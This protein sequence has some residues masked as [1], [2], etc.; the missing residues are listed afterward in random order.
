MRKKI[1]STT[2]TRYSPSLEVGLSNEEVNKRKEDGLVNKTI[3][4]VG[5]SYWEI[6]RT[7]VLSFFNILLFTIAGF[8]IYAN[9]AD[10]DPNTKWYKGIFFVGVLISNII[11][12]LYQDLKAK[13]LMKKMKLI[14][15]KEV[16]V[17]R[18]KELI[19]INP[20]EIVLDDIISFSAGEQIVS[21]SI[22][23]EGTVTVNESLLTGE[24]DNIVKTVG[25]LIYS[26]TYVVS[27]KCLAQ[28]EKVG[29]EN[30][31]ETLAVKAK[32]FK[33]NPSHILKSLKRL[34]RVLGGIIIAY[35]LIIFVTYACLG[36]FS[37][38]ENFISIITPI[39][40]QL[41]A[42]IPAGL[43]LLTSVAL[44]S[45]VVSLFAKK[46]NVQD[47]YS[48]EMLARTDVLCT[49]KTGTITDG[50]M[51]VKEVIS[52]GEMDKKEISH[53]MSK[54]CEENPDS[55][56]TSLSLKE[57]FKG[58]NSNLK[59]EKFLAF[60]SENKYSAATFKTGVSYVFGAY[61]FMNLSNKKETIKAAEE[62]LKKGYRVLTVAKGMGSIKKNK[63]EGE[64]KAIGL[65]IIQ[66]HI[67]ED[68][69]ATFEWFRN[70]HVEIKV[71]SGDNAIT[72]SEIAKE[73]GVENAEKY[74]SLEGMSLEEVEKVAL[75]Y[76]V[77]GRVTPE[78]KEALVKALKKAKKTVA[79]TGDGV[80]DILALKRA[81]CSIAMDSGSQAA[82]N[83][84]HIVLMDNN[85]STMPSIVA[86]GRRVINNLQR[87]GSLF[88]TKTVFAIVISIGFWI[89]SLFNRHIA[90]PFTTNNLLVWE[91]LGIGLS[92]FF[93]ALEPNSAPIRKGFLSHILHK[94]I[95]AAFAIIFATAMCFF[96]F[97]LQNSGI[98]Y[99]GVGDLGFDILHNKVGRF[100]ATGMAVLTYSFL[101]FVMLYITCS[102]L[103]KYRAAVVIGAT[104]VAVIA[105]IIAIFTSPEKNI[106]DVNFNKISNENL[107]AVAIIVISI[108]VIS[109]FVNKMI[110]ILKGLKEDGQNQ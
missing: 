52:L 60:T 63:Y 84:S 75:D 4:V 106:F 86:E 94:S 101:S 73:A 54:I 107:F 49:D 45:G 83:V 56:V 16:K 11:I 68:A 79:M 76:V 1:E 97:W 90:Y 102:P 104:S 96:L 31:V 9:V 42:M 13:H 88:L 29:K 105:H 18:N 74:I 77:F 78:Q 57:Y 53:I 6:L 108:G 40:G 66:D 22:I 59:I 15:T 19:S 82:K 69:K 109:V 27:G 64:L 55:N 58:S 71:I 38:K 44:A 85:F 8:M 98:T 17:L 48:I 25:D 36:K 14:S 32:A 10:G 34:F 30:Y 50:T 37:S 100:G 87:T 51:T 81:D 91:T 39:G 23:K 24:S 47:L 2:V 65:I 70:N 12:G 99:T 35:S 62:Y 26:G 33:R 80:N 67:K 95:P 41:V 61:E 92:A 72:V 28:V 3:L 20:E 21:D 93:V 46:A 43:S 103:T 7:D 5:K 110:P 89:A